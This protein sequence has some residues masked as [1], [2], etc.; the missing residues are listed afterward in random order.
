MRIVRSVI[1]SPSIEDFKSHRANG[2]P[3]TLVHQPP[4]GGE[5][6]ELTVTIIN[7]R[8]NGE[9]YEFICRVV[10]TGAT[11]TMSCWDHGSTTSGAN[12]DSTLYFDDGLDDADD[13]P[14]TTSAA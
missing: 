13:C 11:F 9:N 8:T 7:E 5:E 14:Q 12:V 6:R 4:L 3:I 1:N 2:D 10:D